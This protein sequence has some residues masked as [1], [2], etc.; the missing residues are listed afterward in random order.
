[1][2]EKL[3]KPS[4]QEA[5]GIGLTVFRLALAEG[6]VRRIKSG[7]SILPLLGVSIV[8]DIG[9]GVI[10]RKLNIDTPMRRFID[11]AVD[12]L[13]VARVALEMAKVNEAAKPH[14][15][16]LAAREIAVTAINALHTVQ[17]GNV[18][19]AHGIYNC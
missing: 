15:Q 17:T 3:G 8:T 11:A 13:S 1:M 9:D 10:A 14:L 5:I 16:V 6:M 7:K 19:Q 18:V 4:A 2:L 12:R